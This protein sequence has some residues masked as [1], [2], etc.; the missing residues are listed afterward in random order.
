MLL[1]NR[2]LENIIGNYGLTNLSVINN[3]AFF[4]SPKD[5]R[6]AYKLQMAAPDD[7]MLLEANDYKKVKRKNHYYHP[8]RAFCGDNA[9][10]EF[11]Q[12]CNRYYKIRRTN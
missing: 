12:W 2:S 1:E 8:V 7:L 3:D 4:T 6:R 10:I 11:K 5:M 9:L